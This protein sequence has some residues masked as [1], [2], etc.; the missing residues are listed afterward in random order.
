MRLG[1]FLVPSDDEWVDALGVA[2]A[3]DEDDADIS[4]VGFESDSATQCS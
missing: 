1:E 2:P 3:P 4:C